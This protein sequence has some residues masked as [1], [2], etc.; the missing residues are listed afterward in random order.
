MKEDAE[1]LSSRHAVTDSYCR[2]RRRG[3]TY[4]R[5]SS[6]C[7]HHVRMHAPKLG[8]IGWGCRAS[9]GEAPPL[10][11]RR[12]VRIGPRPA[13]PGCQ[14]LA[15]VTPPGPY[16]RI[17]DHVPENAK[18]AWKPVSYRFKGPDFCW[19]AR[20]AAALS[21]TTHQYDHNRS[22]LDPHSTPAPPACGI[23]PV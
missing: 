8:H 17:G 23:G 5:V 2:K 13:R 4:V 9:H 16:R 14:A 19:L 11:K 18:L 22:R 20:S 21:F 1:G 6:T 3:P 12:A 7:Y 10:R 15:A